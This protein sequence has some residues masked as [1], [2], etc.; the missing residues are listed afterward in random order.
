M[1][2]LDSYAS[3]TAGADIGAGLSA[4]PTPQLVIGF[5]PDALDRWKN[6]SRDDHDR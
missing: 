6:E 5:D 3:V 4:D 1:P 2:L